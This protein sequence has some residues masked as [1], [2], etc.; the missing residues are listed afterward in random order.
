MYVKNVS[1]RTGDA[2]DEFERTQHPE[3]AQH[4]QVQR[5]AR[6]A[7]CRESQREQPAPRGEDTSISL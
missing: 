4:A 3:G 2:A 5:E 7:Q 1:Q 6:P